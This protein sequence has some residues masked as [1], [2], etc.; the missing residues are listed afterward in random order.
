MMLG[1][2]PWPYLL[3]IYFLWRNVCSDHFLKLF[4]CWL[5]WVFV[6]ASGLSLAAVR[7]QGYSLAVVLGLLVAGMGSRVQASAVVARGLRS[8]GP[9]HTRDWTPVSCTRRQILNHWTTGE[10]PHV[11][12]SWIIF[13]LSYESSLY[14]GHPL[15]DV[16]QILSKSVVYLHFLDSVF[17][18]AE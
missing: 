16:W 3:F 1:I 14:S 13:L 15:S 8:C 4:I 2:F 10:V 9:S 11:I 5:C 6:A 17:P 18:R 12:F 7:W